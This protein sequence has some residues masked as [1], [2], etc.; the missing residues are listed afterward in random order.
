[1]DFARADRVEPGSCIPQQGQEPG[2]VVGLHRTADLEPVVRNKAVQIAVAFDG[3]VAVIYIKR[4]VVFGRQLQQKIG[5]Q[6]V[7]LR[8]LGQ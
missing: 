8:R 5:I 2:V 1:M 7:S 3:H 4:R 6:H